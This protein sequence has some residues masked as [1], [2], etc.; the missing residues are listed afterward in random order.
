MAPRKTP[1]LPP[2]TPTGQQASVAAI[3]QAAA[4]KP[5]PDAPADPWAALSAPLAM[6]TKAPFSGVKVNVLETVPE[7]IR[8]RAEA[9]LA[10]NAARVAKKA[11]STAKR[12]RVDY[13]WDV[14]P[15]ALEATAATFIKL[16]TKYAKYR[17]SD[18]AIPHA[19]PDSP[20]GQVT[21]RCGAIGHYIKGEDGTATATDPATPGAFIGVRYSVRPFEQRSDSQR[22]PGTA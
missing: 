20:K 6:P 5:P 1:P 12:S 16:I 4:N 11:D 7:P 2:R 3:E 19:S 22:V 8:M 10:I 14:Q 15:F 18:V 17:P 13:H 21:A 9:S